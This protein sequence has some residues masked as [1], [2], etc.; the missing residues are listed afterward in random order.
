MLIWLPPFNYTEPTVAYKIHCTGRDYNR[1]Y[2]TS[3]TAIQLDSLSENTQ[4]SCN[5]S[6]GA[7]DIGYFDRRIETRFYTLGEFFNVFIVYECLK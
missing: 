1:I 3:E 6:V 5:V 2:E 7:K 4:Y